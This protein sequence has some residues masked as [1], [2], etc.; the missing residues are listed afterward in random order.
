MKR[1]IGC[2]YEKKKGR[3]YFCTH[4]RYD[5][6]ADTIV[7]WFAYTPTGKVSKW[8]HILRLNADYYGEISDRRLSKL[9][10]Q[11]QIHFPKLRKGYTWS[12][13]YRYS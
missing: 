5:R 3:I 2:P 13:P 1:F 9:I 8:W 10:S 7:F 11:K 4:A 6:P 12:E